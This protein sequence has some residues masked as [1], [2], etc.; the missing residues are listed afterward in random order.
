MAKLTAHNQLRDKI[1]ERYHE[2]PPLDCR[3]CGR[4]AELPAAEFV[5]TEWSPTP[6]GLRKSRGHRERNGRGWRA[7][8][9][10]LPAFG[11]PLAII[12]VMDSNPPDAKKLA[13]QQSIPTA[14]YVELDALDSG[15]FKGWCSCACWRMQ[16]MLDGARGSKNR[17][18]PKHAAN[19]SELSIERC[20]GRDFGFGDCGVEF[21]PA[22]RRLRDWD[23]PEAA[24]CLRCAAKYGQARWFAPGEQ[25]GGAPMILPSADA[26]PMDVFRAWSDAA[27]WARI[28]R[29]RVR[30]P[31]EPK[32]G[33]GDERETAAR[34]NAVESAFERG[35]WTDGA[36][37]L[38]PVGNN[39]LQG[40]DKPAL[41]AWRAE[42]CR[43]V[44]DAWERLRD[45]LLARLP[46][47]V[48]RSAK[49]AKPRTAARRT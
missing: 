33:P 16:T 34:M 24:F 39:W 49:V 23:N 27:F 43:R 22:M 6:R 31:K 18:A 48:A 44:A 5:A 14:F 9:A 47:D 29:L 17:F 11:G 46:R 32:R 26:D 21:W 40:W 4:S 2:L 1:A 19:V 8:V 3:L 35:N 42:N 13:A 37:L 36:R 20:S 25:S 7:D 30:N 38:Y 28:W 41:W 10:A 12:E 45:H 15:G